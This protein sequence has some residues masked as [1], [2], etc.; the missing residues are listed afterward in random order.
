MQAEVTLRALRDQRRSLAVWVVALVL[1]VAMYVAIFPSV[2]GDSSYAKLIDGLPKAYRALITVAGGGDITSP[3]GYL[4]VELMTFMGPLLVFVYAIGA[5][6]GAL[7]GEEERHTLDFLLATPIRRERVVVEQFV[8]LCAGTAVLVTAMWAALVA[9]G[10][11]A[12]MAV[13]LGD[14]AAAMLHLGLLGVEFGA[15]ALFVGALTGRLGPSRALPTVVAVVAYLV[16]ALGP[17]VSWLRPLRPYSPFYQYIAHDPLRTGVSAP[18]VAVTVSSILVL[19][20]LSA[21][22]FRRRDVT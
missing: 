15:L 21:V 9:E 13:P 5:G 2:R 6:A 16:N 12:G 19:V 8:A 7:A 14:A 20:A 18:A 17:I 11:M 3:V 1:L 10:A 4:D 22:A